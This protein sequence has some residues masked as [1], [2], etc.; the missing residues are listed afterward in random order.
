MWPILF[1]Y[2]TGGKKKMFN[3]RQ[4]RPWPTEHWQTSVQSKK[5]E[6]ESL[7]NTNPLKTSPNSSS[8]L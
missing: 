8:K 6:I 3:I 1:T 7:S 5:T 2:T 4:T